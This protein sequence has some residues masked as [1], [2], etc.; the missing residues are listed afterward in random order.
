MPGKYH[1]SVYDCTKPSPHM[2]DFY[3]NQEPFDDGRPIPCAKC[4][5]TPLLLFTFAGGAGRCESCHAAFM[6]R[7]GAA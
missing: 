5:K 6:K 7:R 2:A 4:H 3:A 1:E